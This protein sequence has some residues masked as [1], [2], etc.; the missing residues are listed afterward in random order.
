MTVKLSADEPWHTLDA[1]DVIQRAEVD[2]EQGLDED[3]VGARFEAFGKN[4]IEKAQVEPWWRILLHQFTDPLI[5]ILLIAA[6]IT[7]LLED[8]VDMG[9]ILA[10]VLINASIGFYQELRARNAMESLAQMSA[11]RAV[12]IRG[13]REREIDSS[14]VVPGDIVVLRSGNRVPA[15]VRIIRATDLEVNESALTGESVPVRKSSE[16]VSDRQAVP[17]DQVGMAFSSTIVTRGRGR[18]VV[19]RTG[20]A[21]QIGRIAGAA[22]A[23]GQ[24][25]TPIQKKMEHLGHMIGAA[26]AVLAVLMVVVGM[27]LGMPFE[28]V[29]LTAVAMAVGAV[30]EA[31]PVVL[32][33][34]LA[35]GVQRMARR[36]AI[37]RSL[38]AVETLGSTTV[39][40]S[41]K[42]GTL[43]TNEMTVMAVYAGGRR[44]DVT[45]S[46]FVPEGEFTHEGE[47][48]DPLTDDAVKTTLLCAVLASE[49][50]ELPEVEE[51]M[52]GD[53]TEIALLVTAVK[54]GLDLRKEREANEQLDFIPFESERQFMATLNRTS[55]GIRVFLK[56]A[57][58]AVL[59]LCG[60][61][62]GDDG[63]EPLDEGHLREVAAGLAEDGYRVLAMAIRDTDITS[64]D[65][66]DPGSD[67]VFA[68]FQAMEDPVRPEAIDAVDS[69]HSAGVRVL[70][71]TGD[72]A[73]TARSIGARL[74]I[75]RDNPRVVEGRELGEMD[76][77]QLDE[78]VAE[79]DLYARVA[80]EH[81]MRIVD[82]LKARGEVVAVT[83]DG[84]NDAPALRSAHLGVA[85]GRTGT[86]VAREASDMVLV[87]DN[88]ASITSAIEEG[89]VVFSNI[90]KV[91]YFLLSTGASIVLTI[92]FALF[93]GW[94]LP[95]LAAQ[96]LWINLVT[97]GLQD[98][99]LA[100]EPGEPGLLKE[101]PRPSGEG[102][103]NRPVLLRIV[104]I[105]VFMTIGTLA[106]FYYSLPLGEEVARTMAM[107]QMVFFQ[108]FHVFNARSLHR[109]I[110]KVPLLSNRFL[111]GSMVLALIAHGLALYTPWLQTILRTT[112]LDLSQIGLLVL[113]GASIV[114]VSEIDKAFFMRRRG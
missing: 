112:P 13:G 39:V 103:I 80:P 24:V 41:D 57:P 20:Q 31:L 67:L 85:M 63:P 5:Y 4:E 102:V 56:G 51:E 86:D 52:T 9:V 61:Q 46:G 3:Q 81:K 108:F 109:S 74:H 72:H 91:T 110:F 77:A 105:G 19:V 60:S 53:P 28:E 88:F 76:D 58:E 70:M 101:R 35:V 17:G 50:E 43:T 99:A 90:R 36:N 92:L 71:I 2:P 106:V 14:G 44:I 78:V 6:V 87:D 97:N 107:T 10:V 69:A 49:S 59:G 16:A 30:P 73:T 11:A 54:A 7:F 66:T 15:D 8:Y 34:T 37:I 113:V 40:C 93:V 48:I 29:V 18:A 55:E 64:F 68:G 45:G 114:V 96:V 100:F 82:R 111:F 38:P 95:Y 79:V 89:R 65:G 98:V 25:K 27:A 47:T 62:L 21:S 26:V 33:V 22:Q 75:G 32:T 104:V 42:T 1:N 84:V 94:P 12:V 83:G 23:V